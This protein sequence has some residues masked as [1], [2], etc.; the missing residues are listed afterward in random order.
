MSFSWV[1]EVVCYTEI[2]KLSIDEL[3]IK[4]FEFITTAKQANN[5]YWDFQYTKVNL[6]EMAKNFNEN[7]VGTEIPIDINHEKNHKAFA[8]I[9]P[10]SMTVKA[11]SKIPGEFSLYWKLY[12]YTP[13]WKELV[14][15]GAYRY[16]SIQVEER[17]FSKFIWKIKKS[18]R[19]VIRAIALTNIPAIKNMAPT[20]SEK[21]LISKNK[22]MGKFYKKLSEIL[23][24]KVILLSEIDVLKTLS[25]D[26]EDEAEKTEAEDSIKEVEELQ[27]E[28][29]KT[30]DDDGDNDGDDD[31]KSDGTGDDDNKGKE[32]SEKMLSEFNDMKKLNQ[33]VRTKLYSEKL[34]SIT[35][36]E[37]NKT[38][39]KAGAKKDVLAFLKTL[40]DNQVDKYFAI[41]QNIITTVDLT[42]KGSAEIKSK[43]LNDDEKQ[44]N[45]FTAEIKAYSE[46]H[47]VSV[48]DA[49]IAIS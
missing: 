21:N 44:A 8:W 10:G 4:E 48:E 7:V 12:R 23:K 17:G 34:D 35:F 47:K 18:F 27:E 30:K 24:S 45:E 22:K 32:F 25:E 1:K 29:D 2:E 36:S 28:Q 40:S 16:F 9:K 6:Q 13:E 26:I 5:F 38:G 3:E 11:S 33:E 42:E 15:T 19:N 49:M 46:K 37:K 43:E 14:S 39:L 41:H 20:F 31:G